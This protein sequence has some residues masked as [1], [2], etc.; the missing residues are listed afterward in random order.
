VGDARDT[1]VDEHDRSEHT[2][3]QWLYVFAIF[4]AFLQGGK[5]VMLEHEIIV[6]VAAAREPAQHPE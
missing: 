6:Q 1:C 4:V 5:S 3:L 2:V